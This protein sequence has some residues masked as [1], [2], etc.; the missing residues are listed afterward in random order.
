MM[1]VMCDLLYCLHHDADCAAHRMPTEPGVKAVLSLVASANESRVL[2]LLGM[3]NGGNTTRRRRLLGY[4][5][6][7]FPATRVLLQ[8]NSTTNS[9][10]S[11]TNATG[12]STNSTTANINSTTASAS[13]PLVADW[14]YM[15]DYGFEAVPGPDSLDVPPLPPNYTV[16]SGLGPDLG[17]PIEDKLANSSSIRNLRGRSESLCR[18]PMSICSNGFC[19]AALHLLLLTCIIPGRVPANATILF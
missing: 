2:Q 1:A 18:M 15:A 13:V 12:N 11:S 14:S 19:G 5:E 3:S 17:H 9:T 6:G 7:T 16:N 10:V 4:D 8:V